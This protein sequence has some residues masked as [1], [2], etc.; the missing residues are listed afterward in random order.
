MTE[1][2]LI[3]IAFD[4]M[5]SDLKAGISG[6]LSNYASLM[7]LT[8]ING[9]F[10]VQFLL[11]TTAIAAITPGANTGAAFIDLLLYLLFTAKLF[12]DIR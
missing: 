1:A 11:L 8:Q 10:S 7:I 2:I 6:C 4:W 9:L 3:A 12:Y 5:C